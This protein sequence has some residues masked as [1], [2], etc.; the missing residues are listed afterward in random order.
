MGL[1]LPSEVLSGEIHAGHLGPKLMRCAHVLDVTG[2]GCI[3]I[4]GQT[5]LEL[6]HLILKAFQVVQKT[7]YSR[8][9][10]NEVAE[11]CTKCGLR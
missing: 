11:N 9:S 3:S 2:Q 10:L 4:S 7:V 6:F 1:E 5:V 8:R